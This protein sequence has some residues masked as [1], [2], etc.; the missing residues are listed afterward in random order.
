[1]ATREAQGIRGEVTIVLR[2]PRTDQI[3]RRVGA[4]NAILA[5]GSELVARR[6]CTGDVP[7][8][9]AVGVGTSD[10]TPEDASLVDLVAPVM[11]N[12]AAS[13]ADIVPIEPGA[14]FVT[15]EGETAVAQF[16]ATFAAAQ[17]VGELREAGIFNAAG[18]LYNRVVFD[19]ITK[20]SSHE[21]TL[22]WKIAFGAQT[23][24]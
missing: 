3:L 1:M 8:V 21:L 13:R 7:P 18:T 5:G 19:V 23:E 16:K 14:P 10:A 9:A 24:G 4:K 2:D 22:L 20:G 11:D 12:G 17:G 6:F 15:M